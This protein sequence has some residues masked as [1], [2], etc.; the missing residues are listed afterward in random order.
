MSRKARLLDPTYLPDSLWNAKTGTLL[1][2]PCLAL[3][4][5]KV[6]DRHG[7]RELSNTRRANDAPIGGKSKER[8]ELHF[9]QQYDGSV[10]RVQLAISDPQN[11][12]HDVSDAIIKALS[13]NRITLTDAPCGAGAASFSFLS[14]IAELRAQSILPREPLDVVLLGAELSLHARG[15]AEELLVEL[16][17][18]FEKQGIFVKAS[19]FEW[20]A[21]CQVSTAELVRRMNL[22]CESHPFNLIV[23]ANFSGFLSN[24][25]KIRTAMPQLRDLF[26][27]GS[28][29]RNIAIWIEP[30]MKKVSTASGGLFSRIRKILKNSWDQFARERNQPDELKFK[31]TS[32]AKFCLPLKKSESVRVNLAVVSLDL[33]R[34][35]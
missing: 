7:L 21:T 17:P 29:K 13:G 22:A 5:E 28:G 9:A 30:N 11:D 23:V 19:F 15:L 35:Q 3:A 25:G 20:D 8:T 31:T 12:I 32:A 24:S 27:H 10:A 6:I 26:L 33:E 14:T 34:K 2:A 4:Y 16:S 1:I 18:V